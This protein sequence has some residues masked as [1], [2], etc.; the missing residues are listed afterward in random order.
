MKAYVGTTGA[1]FGALTVAHVW[2]V[3][4]E[5]P[6]LARDPVFLIVTVLAAFLCLWACYLLRFPSRT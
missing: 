3:L 1:V 4:E 6:Q 2:R 5:G